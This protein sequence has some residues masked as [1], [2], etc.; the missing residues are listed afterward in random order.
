VSVDNHQIDRVSDLQ[1]LIFGYKPGQTV[2]V[3]VM[4]F[5]TNRTFRL[6]LGEPP[7]STQLASGS[8]G[9]ESGSGIASRR[10]GI[11]VAPV[12]PAI[13]AQFGLSGV[14]QGLVV[15][16][17]DESGPAFG[18]LSPNDVIIAALGEGGVRKPMRSVDDLQD[19]VRHPVN[20][21]VSLII[22]A[23]S[24]NG[25][26]PQQRVANILLSQTGGT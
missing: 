26:A 13:A 10:L 6:T 24:P 15:A 17:V 3:D 1:R 9:E 8:S 12:T 19:A 5:G 25:G 18:V 11:T 21:A 2:P 20:G 7:A 16:R 22:A 4:R 23:P 14:T